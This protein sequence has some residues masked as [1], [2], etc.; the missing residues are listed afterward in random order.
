V[1]VVLWLIAAGAVAWVAGTIWAFRRSRSENATW[2][3]RLDVTLRALAAI[4]FVSLGLV[5]LRGDG[6]LGPRWLAWKALLF[7]LIIAF[8]LWIRVAAAR[9][10][11]ALAELLERGESPARLAAVNRS[12]RGVYPPVLAVWGTLILITVIAVTKP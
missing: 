12:I 2:F 4:G 5:S 10:R 9:Y 11:P 7:G 3:S 6:P 1:P 8:G